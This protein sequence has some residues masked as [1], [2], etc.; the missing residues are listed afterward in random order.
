MAGGGRSIR[1]APGVPVLW[2]ARCFTAGEERQAGGDGLRDLFSAIM[3]PRALL[4][5]QGWNPGI[6]DTGYRE[7]SGFST[8]G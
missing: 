6:I 4:K 5:V 7:E 2:V 8:C 3:S 1:K